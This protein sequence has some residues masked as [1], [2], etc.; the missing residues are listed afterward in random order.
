MPR[1][2]A[3]IRE[4]IPPLTRFRGGSKVQTPR[5]RF[6][7]SE[8]LKR[9]AKILSGAFRDEE[10]GPLSLKRVS[11]VLALVCSG[12]LLLYGCSGSA[13]LP[14]TASIPPTPSVPYRPQTPYFSNTTP[15]PNPQPKLPPANPW[16]P[17]G[18]PRD[19]KY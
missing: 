7:S 11:V 4:E 17:T 10:N 1:N 12:G 15:L 3:K 14:P 8:N 5:S 13:V 16:K 2:Q 18:T 6:G 9:L 19:W